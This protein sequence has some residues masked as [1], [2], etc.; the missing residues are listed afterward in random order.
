[1][2]RR[3]LA[4]ASVGL[5]AGLAGTAFAYDPLLDAQV[6]FA[7][8]AGENKLAAGHYQVG[9]P[10]QNADV[11]EVKNLDTGKSVLVPYI[12]RLAARSKE[13]IALVFDEQGNEASLS[14]VHVPPFDG[15]YVH[16]VKGAHT[17][18]IIT[19]MKLK[20]LSKKK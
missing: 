12:T 17:H 20:D 2:I 3:L 14:E 7:F 19:G 4:V 11:L 1:M 8:S 18:K 5:L 10:D 16:G 6:P 13:D 9:V 15:Y